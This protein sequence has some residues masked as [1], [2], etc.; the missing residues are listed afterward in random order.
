M[1]AT[2]RSTREK[3]RSSE[4]VCVCSRWNF[5]FSF[6]LLCSFFKGTN[7]CNTKANTFEQLCLF[8]FHIWIFLHRTAKFM[9]CCLWLPQCKNTPALILA[10][11]A[12]SWYWW[13]V[14]EPGH[15][16]MQSVCY[17]VIKQLNSRFC[18]ALEAKITFRL[19]K[20]NAKVQL[21]N[22]KFY[23]LRKL[24][25]LTRMADL[26]VATAAAVA[27]MG[28]LLSDIFCSGCSDVPTVIWIFNVWIL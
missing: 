9:Y 3:K 21:Q 26:E 19:H 15:N 13:Q 7:Q 8:W 2:K 18:S 11:R 17:K 28:F 22:W 14:S 6:S 24:Q 20:N 12:I 4:R 25:L 1:N 5:I 10:L 23:L 16:S 27:A